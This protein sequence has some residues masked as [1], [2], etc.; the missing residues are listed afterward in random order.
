MCLFGFYTM[1]FATLGSTFVEA[2]YVTIVKHFVEEIVA[3]NP[4]PASAAALSSPALRYETLLVRKLIGIVQ[5]GLVG[6]R[7]LSE[8]VLAI[9]R[10]RQRTLWLTAIQHFALLQVKH[11]E[12]WPVC[13]C[14]K[15][16]D[17]AK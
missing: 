13:R 9:L 8:Q 3:V 15:G 17:E 6:L 12:D 14:C 10:A 4:R 1:L 16:S 7:L 5:R 11:A 2:N